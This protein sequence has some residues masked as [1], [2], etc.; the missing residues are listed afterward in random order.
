M[1]KQ[2]SCWIK[3][4]PATSVQGVLDAVA[5]RSPRADVASSLSAFET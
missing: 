2:D 1:L 3:P 4:V 5:Q